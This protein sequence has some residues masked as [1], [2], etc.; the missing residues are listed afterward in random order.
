MHNKFLIPVYAWLGIK[1]HKE[2]KVHFHLNKVPRFCVP[3]FY[4]YVLRDFL[5]C[6]KWKTSLNKKLSKSFTCKWNCKYR[7]FD[8]GHRQLFFFL[9][10]SRLFFTLKSLEVMK[11][12]FLWLWFF[13]TFSFS[14]RLY[15]WLNYFLSA[16]GAIKSKVDCWKLLQSAFKLAV[17]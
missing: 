14:S 9:G 15:L 12:Y 6:D 5:F 8:V 16:S 13:I 7:C 1:F 10:L 2:W 11:Q 3:I 17:K 4:V